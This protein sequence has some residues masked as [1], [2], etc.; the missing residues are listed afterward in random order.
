[1]SDILR[2]V[3]EE[4]RQDRLINLWRRYRVYLIGGLIL[5]IGSVLGYQINKSVNQSF[6]EEEVEKYIGS[7]DL[8]DINQ[9][10]ENLGEIENSNQLLISGIAQIKIATLLMENGK[11]QESKDKLLEIINE[12]K[13]DDIITDLAIYFYLMSNLN[14]MAMDEINIYIDSDKLKNSPFKFLFKETIAIK[15]LLSGKIQI[16]KEKF[17]ELINDANTPRD[18]VI[19]ATKFLDTIK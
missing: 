18:I 8:V 3:D 12:D 11:I 10:I 2:Q 5:L 14:D 13:T 16:S 7:S 17:D 19:R 1:M 9:T 6:Y 15:N 4:L